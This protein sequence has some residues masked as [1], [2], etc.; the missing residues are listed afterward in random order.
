MSDEIDRLREALSYDPATGAFTWLRTSKRRAT[1]QNAGCRGP[2][3]YV[4]IVVDGRSYL[5]HRLAWAF[6][7]G[8]WPVGQIDHMNMDRSDNR[9]ANLREAD[10]STNQ[11][12]TRIR[13][14]NTSGLKG[15]T[16]NARAS[17]WQA[18]IKKN[19]A[20]THLGLFD[21][22]EAAHAAYCR[23]AETM[24]ADFRRTA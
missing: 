8:R 4:K 9:I 6:T 11:A 7:Q 15:V 14:D 24:F 18:Q 13:A 21:T 22:K 20:N 3:G 2:R 19:G 12:N 23:A 1:G 10:H 17:K 16:F 5:A